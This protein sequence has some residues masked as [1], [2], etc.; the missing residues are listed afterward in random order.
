M[1]SEVPLGQTFGN[2]PATSSLP[3]AGWLAGWRSMVRSGVDGA[4]TNDQWVWNFQ[5]LVETYK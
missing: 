1:R 5:L 2:L 4:F 3:L